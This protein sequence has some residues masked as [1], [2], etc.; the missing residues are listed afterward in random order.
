VLAVVVAGVST[1][2]CACGPGTVGTRGAHA[3]SSGANRN[4]TPVT[5]LRLAPVGKPYTCAPGPNE[6][7]QGSF[8]DASAIGWARNDEGVVACLGGSFYVQGA[9]HRTFG[10]GVY[11]DTKTTWTNLDGYLPALVTSFH[12]FGA[13]ISITNFGDELQIAGN[14]YVAIYSRVAVRNPT[15]H[16]LRVDPGA[17]PGLVALN[18][19]PVE[20]KAHGTVDHDYVVAVDRF[21]Q[22]Y[23]WPSKSALVGAG[24]F[25]QHLAH[26][27]SFWNAQLA[28]I[29]QLQLPD[30]QLVDAYRSGFIYTQIARSGV[31]LDTGV[32]NYQSEYSH[33]VVGI[34]ANL[35]TQGDFTDAQELLTDAR[36]VVG[37]QIQYVDGAWTYAWPWAIYLLKTGDLAF[38]RANFST[39]GPTGAS[40]PSIEDTAHLIATDRTGPGGIM[41]TTDDIDSDG[42]WTIDDYEALMGLAAYRYLAQSLGN[43]PETTWATE[44]YDSL[45][46]ATNATLDATISRYHLDY[47]PCSMVQPNSSNRCRN[48]ED[49][50]WAAPFLFGRWAW[51]GSLFGATL[52]GPGIVLIDSTYAYG[53]KRLV[54]RLPANTVGGYPVA[55]YYSSGYNA[56]Y[57]SWGLASQDYRD[58]GILGYQFMIDH[59]QSGPYSWW[60]SANA[61]EAGSPWVGSHPGGGQGSAPHSWGIANANKVL[62]DSLTAQR[63]DGALIVGRG[64]PDSWVHTGPALAVSNFP[65]TDG[66]RLGF[67]ISVRGLGVT[68]TLQGAHPSGPVLFELPAFVNNIT[69]SSAGTVDAT[70]GTVTLTP[71]VT[72]VTV[73]LKHSV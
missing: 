39:E 64:I 65:T 47:L 25:E 17:S 19:A 41:G 31:H 48:P 45:L 12:R 15:G 35:F 46:A 66:Q 9:L 26:M 18:R 34:L 8:G 42:L 14:E 13:D 10:F 20:V 53:F 36:S 27:R 24:R 6:A 43:A 21:G 29:A 44:Q 72:S 1:F 30:T 49:A 51:D 5:A 38:V 52:S 7:I 73:E 23:P 33:D 68:L 37:S 40:E 2:A 61:P 71:S 54:G 32:N 28:T 55:Y 63:S 56:G 16:T 69:S 59:S 3:G 4:T 11:D 57:G 67:T 22:N 60:E 70:S 58:Q 50:N 62:L